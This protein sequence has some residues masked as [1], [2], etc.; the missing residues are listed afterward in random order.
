MTVQIIDIRVQDSAS[1]WTGRDCSVVVGKHFILPM[2]FVEN[3]S[4]CC[5]YFK[6]SQIVHVSYKSVYKFLQMDQARVTRVQIMIGCDVGE[7][8]D[9]G[10]KGGKNSLD[11]L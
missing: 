3:A 9:I 11:L 5:V 6:N 4:R 1:E 7:V 8:T 10:P 2:G